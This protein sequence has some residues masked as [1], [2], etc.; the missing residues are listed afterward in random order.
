MKP[1]KQ[2]I[3][4][5]QNTSASSGK[6]MTCNQY[7]ICAA[8][9]WNSTVYL[10]TSLCTGSTVEG[11]QHSPYLE[12]DTFIE[13]VI[14]QGGITGRIRRWIYFHQGELLVYDISHNRW[15][16]NIK[17]QH[18][19][20]NIMQV[21]HFH[22]PVYRCIVFESI[23]VSY[24]NSQH[25]VIFRLLADIRRGVYY[26]KCHDPDCKAIDYKSEGKL[27]ISFIRLRF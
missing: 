13:S 18:K 9:I 22:I 16:H 14:T 11:Y 23:E 6:Y 25:Q 17:R 24:E 15:C 20:N 21:V 7:L 10:M 3:K 19:G 27:F 12:I 5:I 4:D 26:Q 2:H 8:R 1:R